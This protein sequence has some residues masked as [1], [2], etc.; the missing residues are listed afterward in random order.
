MEE[1][2]NDFALLFKSKLDY[3]SL[4]QSAQTEMAT[5]VQ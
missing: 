3:K 4:R 1:I 5:A 2:L